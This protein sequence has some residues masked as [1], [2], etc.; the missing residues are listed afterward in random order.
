M[1]SGSKGEHSEHRRA[2]QTH[3]AGPT[4]TESAITIADGMAVRAPMSE[5][6]EIIRRG[7]DRIVRVTDAGVAGAI[8]AY[9]EDT[10]NLAEGAGAAPL[11]ALLKERVRMKGKRVGLVLSGANISRPLLARILAGADS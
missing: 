8:R 11:A 7:A 4:T 10:H 1:S 5:V 9:H 3:A 6:I 2:T